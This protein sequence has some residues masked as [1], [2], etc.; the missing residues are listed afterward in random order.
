MTSDQISL[1]VMLFSALPFDILNILQ[2]HNLHTSKLEPKK[3]TGRNRC[4]AQKN[5]D[6]NCIY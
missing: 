6:E 3:T 5:L 2:L 1:S 4:L